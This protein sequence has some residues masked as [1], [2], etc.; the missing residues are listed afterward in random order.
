MPFAV[1]P[2]V[3][4]SN[5]GHVSALLDEPLFVT[6]QSAGIELPERSVPRKRPHCAK[7]LHATRST[8]VCE[9]DPASAHK[10]KGGGGG[11]GGV[12]LTHGN[13]LASRVGRAAR[14][15]L[16]VVGLMTFNL[17]RSI[18]VAALP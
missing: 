11:G 17:S 10:G 8:Q 15:Q 6:S 9:Q 14:R 16:S 1:I 13:L 5:L 18:N 4:H 2:S 3:G 7:L 12:Q